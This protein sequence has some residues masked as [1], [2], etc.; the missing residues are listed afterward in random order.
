MKEILLSSSVRARS[1]T[2]SLRIVE[3]VGFSRGISRVVDTTWLDRVGIPVFAAIRPNGNEETLCVHAGKGLSIEEAKMG[4]FMEAVEF[5]FADPDGNDIDWFFS[6]PR[7][8]IESF[9][10]QIKFIDFCPLI[11]RRV[12][13]DDKIAVV[14]AEEISAGIGNVLVPA[15]LV[16]HPFL[17]LGGA[18]LYGT[19]T[20]GLASGNNL[21]EATIHGIAEVMERHVRSFEILDDQSFLVDHIG[22]PPNV[23]KLL[24]KIEGAGLICCL[25]YT[26]NDF[27]IPYFSA[28]VLEPD[29]YA[30]ISVALGFGFH[31]IKEVAAVKAITEALQGR[32]SHIHGGRDDIIDRVDFAMEVGRDVEL[33][34]IRILREL[35]VDASR[36]MAF[37]EVPE[38]VISSPSLLNLKNIL[39]E[40]LRLAGFKHIVRVP[41]SPQ[42]YPFS[43]VKIIIPGAE[44]YDPNYRRLGSRLLEHIING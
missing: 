43:V 3:A 12:C 27:G 14:W 44:G 40:G 42:D 32:L 31:P 29:E 41:L 17:A 26:E 34:A 15:E 23:R 1:L 5:S 13:E 36:S 18:S 11:D 24:D 20:T 4:A 6:S 22:L 30:P 9:K 28:Y 16:F 37:E 38:P 33:R 8:I 7:K 2:D 21:E 10:W 19:T 35:A 25:R 39:L